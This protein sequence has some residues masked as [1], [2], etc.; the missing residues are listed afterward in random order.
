MRVRTAPNLQFSLCVVPQ[1]TIRSVA[2]VHFRESGSFPAGEFFHELS[3]LNKAKLIAL[4][5]IARD[6]GKF[7]NSENLA[8]WTAGCSSSSPSRFACRLP[9]RRTSGGR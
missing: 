6:H 2:R 5:R 7:Y 9:M 1:R 8:I 4:F 3:E